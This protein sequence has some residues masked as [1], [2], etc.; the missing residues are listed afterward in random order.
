[1]KIKNGSFVKVRPSACAKH[2]LD[3][4][5]FYR[6]LLSQ[7]EPPAPVRMKKG[8]WYPPHPIVIE[9]V[10]GG[11]AESKSIHIEDCA[12]V[13]PEEMVPSKRWPIDRVAVL[14]R[15]RRDFCLKEGRYPTVDQKVRHAAREEA[16]RLLFADKLEP[17]N[18]VTQG[19]WSKDLADEWAYLQDMKL[20]AFGIE[21]DR[22][23]V[24]AHGPTP[25]TAAQHDEVEKRM[26]AAD[27][28][29]FEKLQLQGISSEWADALKAKELQICKAMGV[30]ADMVL[31][32]NPSPKD[33]QAPLVTILKE[34]DA[35]KRREFRLKFGD[36]RR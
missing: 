19:G 4:G 21:P 22:F 33:E 26:K 18:P 36:F 25:M 35:E 23:V 28:L 13:T 30:T 1:M 27:D 2:G 34:R 29:H 31:T 12:L 10:H 15:L 17:F 14:Q 20:R 11:H 5:A 7:D 9:V 6:V 32:L 3:T 8:I 24:A 16:K